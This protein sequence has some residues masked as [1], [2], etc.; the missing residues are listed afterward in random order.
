MG[1]FQKLLTRIDIERRLS[2]ADYC[3]DDLPSFEG[4]PAINLLV[5][6]ENSGTEWT[7]RCTFGAEA[8]FRR[9]LIVKGWS[10][11]VR[12]K[13]LKTGDIVILYKEDDQATGRAQYKIKVKK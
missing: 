2:I 7:F 9:L 1:I 4:S 6:D 10:Q 3:L 8:V 11:Y 13:N 12:S 5:K